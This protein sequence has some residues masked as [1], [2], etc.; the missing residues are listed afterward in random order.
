MANGKIRQAQRGDEG[1]IAE[2]MA[3]LWPDGSHAEFEEEAALLIENEMCG[4]LP[5]VILLGLDESGEA[6]GFLQAGL[7]SHADGC[8]ASRPVGF[9]EGWFVRTEWRGQGVGRWLMNAAEEWCRARG[10]RELAS[11]TVLGNVESLRAHGAVGFEVVDRCV[12]F[13]KRL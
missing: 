5:A 10:C 6:I 3:Q 13:R 7:R 2:L 9:I 11:D 4:T 8:D 1:A 12:H